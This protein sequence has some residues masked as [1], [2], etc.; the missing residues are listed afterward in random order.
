[1]RRTIR[2]W[3]AIYQM[4]PAWAAVV[5]DGRRV[6]S[7]IVASQFDLHAEYGPK[8]RVNTLSPAPSSPR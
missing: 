1:M 4:L 8:V 6:E 5:E 3:P 7:N 2:T